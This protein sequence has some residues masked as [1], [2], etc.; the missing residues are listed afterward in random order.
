[1]S[2]KKSSRAKLNYVVDLIIGVGFVLAA[3]SGVVLLVVGSGGYQ[4]G[5]NPRMAQEVL[6]LSRFTWKSLHD[7]AGIALAVGVGLH[8]VLHWKW[9]TCMTRSLFHRRAGRAQT[10]SVA[11]PCRPFEA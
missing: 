11:S 8:L 1:M 6:S 5:R 7:W 2:E 3:V 9:I 4:G 10:A